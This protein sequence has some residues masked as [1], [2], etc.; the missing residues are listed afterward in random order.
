MVIRDGYFERIQASLCS[1]GNGVEGCSH[2]E[3]FEALNF[4]RAVVL[5][6]GG[7]ETGRVREHESAA[8]R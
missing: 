8:G 1:G 4:P 6:I 3:G 2:V 7:S 5:D